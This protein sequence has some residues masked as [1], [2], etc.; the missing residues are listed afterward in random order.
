MLQTYVEG[1][2]DRND[3]EY[4]QYCVSWNVENQ[5]RQAI[6]RKRRG[7]FLFPQGC[8]FPV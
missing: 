4:Y 8:S 1:I 6:L 5:N 2:Y 7:V 3:G